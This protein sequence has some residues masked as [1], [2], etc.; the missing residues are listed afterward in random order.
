M[1]E[2][3]P[4]S[5]QTAKQGGRLMRTFWA[6]RVVG[7]SRAGSRNSKWLFV[8]ARESERIYARFL[9]QSEVLVQL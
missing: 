4:Q 9:S 7:D 3:K 8:S 6:L 2:A 1:A 5:I